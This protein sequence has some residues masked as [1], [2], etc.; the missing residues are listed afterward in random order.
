MPSLTVLRSSSWISKDAD[1]GF[2]VHVFETP[3]EVRGLSARNRCS[4]D[5]QRRCYCPCRKRIPSW[6]PRQDALSHP[7][8]PEPGAAAVTLLP[9]MT[10]HGEPGGVNWITRQS[11]AAKSASSLQ[12]RPRKS[13][14]RDAR[15]RDDDDFEF[16]VDRSRFGGPAAAGMV[17]SL[18]LPA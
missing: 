2:S 16:H 18:I 4:I 13:A 9:K 6:L 17:L 1:A 11:P 7:T 14:W 10:A 3:R 8:V 12:P 5:Q 15:N